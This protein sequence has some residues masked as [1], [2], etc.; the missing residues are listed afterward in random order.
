MAV[1]VKL[2]PFLEGGCILGVEAFETKVDV[3]YGG[4]E[5]DSERF[6]YSSVSHRFRL[7]VGAVEFAKRRQGGC[8]DVE[9]VVAADQ[10]PGAFEDECFGSK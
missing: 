2:A 7:V 5:A 4:R 9:V 1:G 6:V 3:S 8:Q 10:I